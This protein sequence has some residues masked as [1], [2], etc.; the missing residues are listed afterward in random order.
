MSQGDLIVSVEPGLTMSELTS[1]LTSAGLMLPYDPPAPADATL[2]GLLSAGVSGPRRALYGSLRDMAISL[3]VALLD[4]RV[5]RTG[6]KVVKNVAA[7][8]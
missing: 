5:I 7:T 6:A 3:R 8:T 4:G 2:G 1:T